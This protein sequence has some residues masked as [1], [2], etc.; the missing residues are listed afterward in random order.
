[1]FILSCI[2]ADVAYMWMHVTHEVLRYLAIVNNV[3][4][5]ASSNGVCDR[6]LKIIAMQMMQCMN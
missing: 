3:V 5:F 6:T 2:Y 4:I 1:M